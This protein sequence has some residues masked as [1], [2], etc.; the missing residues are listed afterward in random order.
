MRKGDRE[1]QCVAVYTTAGLDLRLLEA[2]EMLRTQLCRDAPR[3]RWQ[4]AS[5]EKQLLASGWSI[6]RREELP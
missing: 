6:T 5:W 3:L 1:V 4:A 2:G